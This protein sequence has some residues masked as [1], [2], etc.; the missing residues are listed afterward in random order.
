VL[1]AME[2]EL[3]QQYLKDTGQPTIPPTLTAYLDDVVRPTLR[4]QKAAGAVAIKFEAAYL[5]SLD[6]A[7]ASPEAADGIYRKHAA[8]DVAPAADY[9][10]LQDHLFHEIAAEAGRLD[11]VVQIHTGVGCGESFDVAGSDPARLTTVF[12]D[13]TLRG[14]TFVM[15]H[16]GA[17]FERHIVGL[18]LKPNVY[19]DTSVLELMQSPQEL[20]RTLRPWLETMPEHVMFGTDAGFFSP[21]MEWIETT[22]L[23]AR[24]TRTALAIAL[25]GMVH[26]GVITFDRAKELAELVLRRTALQIYHLDAH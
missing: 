17:P 6:F 19:A 5:R 21:G 18:I 22:W 4:K 3:L 2:G 1:F 20:A 14:T 13:P 12:N 10:I 16:G 25:N 15:L 11:L 8:G 24:K 7:T 26:D 9:K 23:G